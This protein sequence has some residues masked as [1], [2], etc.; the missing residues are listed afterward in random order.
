LNR[1]RGTE[2]KTFRHR[3]ILRKE[4]S[5]DDND[6]NDD[7]DDADDDDDDSSLEDN[8]VPTEMM[9]PNSLG[10]GCAIDEYVERFGMTVRKQLE[11]RNARLTQSS[12]ST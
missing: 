4:P 11:L 12:M 7:D 2:S 8:P 6:D 3:C 1:L 10:G 5:D 9:D